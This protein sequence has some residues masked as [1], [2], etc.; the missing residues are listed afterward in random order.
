MFTQCQAIHARSILPCQDTPGVKITYSAT[1]TA[2]DGL[3]ALMSALHD[4]SN[5]LGKPFKFYQPVKIP[6]YLI[7]L[8]IGNIVGERVGPRSTVWSEPQVIK[9]AAW[10]FADTELF[11]KTG[12]D[13]LTPYE[14]GV[15]D[16]LLLPASFPYG[17]MENP[18]LTFVTPSLLAKDR[19]L[20]DVVAH[21]I[22]HSWMGNLVTTQNWEHFWLNEGFTVFIERK[23]IGRLHGSATLNLNAI[24]GLGALQE[25]VDGFVKSSH[26]EYT[27]LCPNLHNQDP[28]DAFSSVPYEKGFN[29]LFYLEQ[30][31]GGPQLFEPYLKSHVKKFAHSAITT[32]DF[33]SHLYEFFESS[34]DVLESVDWEGWFHKPGM[35]LVTN[36]FD[37]SL[38]V[39]SRALANR[40]TSLMQMEH[41]PRQQTRHY[42]HRIRTVQL[43]PK[44]HVF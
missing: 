30:L 36:H 27:C 4:E 37:D 26:P 22:A 24:I 13:L 7:A 21:E 25:S 2:P 10:E 5:P 23:I 42:S 11:I 6:S 39:A 16:L 44:S 31:L 32:A 12:E 18:C 9:A 33:K 41:L 14:W 29:L 1:V 17:G 19:S 40:Y 15:Y 20:V 38:A 35:P 43:E 28:D 3:R 34:R 8:A